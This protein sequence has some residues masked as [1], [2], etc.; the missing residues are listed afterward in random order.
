[1]TMPELL[2]IGF[3]VLLSAWLFLPPRSKS[4]RRADA[5]GPPDLPGVKLVTSERDLLT[6]YPVKLAGRPDEVYWHSAYGLIPVETKTRNQ[7]IMS[8]SDKVQL[9]VYAVL[10]RHSKNKALPGRPGRSGRL[11]SSFGYVRFVT[12][13][14]TRWKRVSLLSESD[15]VNLVHRRHDLEQG[16]VSPRPASN[17]KSCQHCPYRV[18][19]PRRMS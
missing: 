5:G 11:V 13:A 16:R 12:P 3:V 17:A 10:L 15:V 7:A 9:S 8:A 6:D 2:V 14:G 4:G 19:C 18:A 1:M